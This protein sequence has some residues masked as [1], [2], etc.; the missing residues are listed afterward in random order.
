MINITVND[1]NYVI[2]AFSKLYRVEDR[3]IGKVQ[4]PVRVNSKEAKSV[5]DAL[6]RRR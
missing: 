5:Y 2:G 4:V 3:D 6:S 1:K